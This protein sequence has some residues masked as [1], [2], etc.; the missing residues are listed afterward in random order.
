[1]ERDRE[2]VAEIV[3]ELLVDERALRRPELD[4][5]AH[6]VA[7]EGR[8][9]PPGREHP[10]ID[11]DEIVVAIIFRP[12]ERRG[13]EADQLAPSHM[14]QRRRDARKV[15]M[16]KHRDYVETQAD[17]DIRKELLEAFGTADVTQVI[18]E[19]LDVANPAH[20]PSPSRWCEAI[21]HA[22]HELFYIASWQ[23]SLR[24]ANLLYTCLQRPRKDPERSVSV[25]APTY[26]LDLKISSWLFAVL[27]GG[28]G[29]TAAP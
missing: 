22:R 10:W 8:R 5:P 11:G 4:E 18:D 20:Q 2:T 6:L 17:R 25:Q 29:S 19:S 1:M 28:A 27:H 23:Q 16:M 15:D 26:S 12:G 24:S 21:A 3:P 9:R 7:S 13:G 14:G